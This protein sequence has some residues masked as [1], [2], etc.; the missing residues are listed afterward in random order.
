MYLFLTLTITLGLKVSLRNEFN[1]W[2]LDKIDFLNRICFRLVS[3]FK[4]RIGL[5]DYESMTV[6]IVIRFIVRQSVSLFLSFGFLRASAR[7]NY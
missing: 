5:L 7:Y 2:N 1:R 3:F 4:K 6:N